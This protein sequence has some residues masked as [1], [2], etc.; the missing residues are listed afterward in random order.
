MNER[1]DIEFLRVRLSRCDSAGLATFALS[2]AERMLP[3]YYRFSREQN[4]GDSGVLRRVLDFGWTWLGSRTMEELP[5]AEMQARCLEQA[6]N[7]EDFVSLYV[8]PALD[9]ANAVAAVIELLRE[10]SV[11]IAIEVATYGRDTVDMYVQEL[12]NMAANDPNLEEQI[13]HHPMMQ[14]ELANQR[15]AIEAI[16]SGITPQAAANRWRAPGLSSIDLN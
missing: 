2:C 9:A 15:D 5:T 6:P 16:Q 1:F 10:P 8:S 3:N 14:R 7:T 4:W 11:D 13:S 12:E